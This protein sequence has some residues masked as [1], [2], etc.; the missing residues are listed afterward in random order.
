MTLFKKNFTPF[1]FACILTALLSSCTTVAPEAVPDSSI[2]WQSRKQ[3]LSKINKWR[4]KGKLA[5]IA[6]QDSGS[7]NFNWVQRAQNFDISLYGPIGSSAVQLNG[8]PG[9]VVMTTGSGNQFTASTPE[10]LLNKQLGWR[11][12]VSYLN[13]WVRGLPVPGG[14][15]S[16]QFDKAH[17]LSKLNQKGFDV[18]FNR[19]TN[20]G[21]IDLPQRITITSSSIKTKIFI[22]N[23]EILH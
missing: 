16:T 18:V 8:R 14:T 1:I 23:W 5:V 19:Y 11:L 22:Y 2:S 6:K 12:P 4:L 9:K 3:T 20:S 7:A 15:Q 21:G 10:E 17:R 13:Y